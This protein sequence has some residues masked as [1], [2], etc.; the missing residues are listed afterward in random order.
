M[1]HLIAW[2][3]FVGAWLLVVG[4]LDQAMRELDDV[5]FE[6]DSIA[7]ASETVEAPPQVSWKW[8]LV[9]PV[10]YWLRRRRDARYKQRI[11]AAMAPEDLRALMQLRDAASAWAYVAAGAALIAVEQTWG[12]HEA[13]EWDTW[14]VWVL[15]AVM[16]GLCAAS[17]ILRLRRRRGVSAGPV[18]STT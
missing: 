4:P 13:Y 2:C 6:R 11:A 7:R 12:L 8:L 15:V 17:A 3:G 9:P 16:L 1:Q 18:T 14:T 10:Y 5:D